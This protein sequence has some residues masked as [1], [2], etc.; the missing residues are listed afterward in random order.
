LGAEILSRFI[1]R[2]ESLG[3][4]HGINMARRCPPISHLLFADDVIIFS[5]ANTGKAGVILKC[6]SSYSSWSG[7]HIN[8]SKSAI[9]FSR[10]CKSSIKEAVNGILYL[11][12]LPSRA[13]YLRIPL[14]MHRSKKESFIDLKD[15]ILVRITWW[16]ARLLSQAARTTLVK[17]V[18]N[19]IPT[20][21]MSLFMLPRSLL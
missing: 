9:F 10:N 12:L 14:F 11:P 15:K 17:S 7:Q 16:K 4:L 5:K 8:M 3:L 1:E 19:A 2:E 18:I 6:L 20:Y 21:L 13:K